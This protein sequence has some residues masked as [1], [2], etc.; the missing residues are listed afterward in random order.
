VKVLKW[1]RYGFLSLGFIYYLSAMITASFLP[2]NF[3]SSEVNSI[4]FIIYAIL[5][6]IALCCEK[7]KSSPLILYNFGIIMTCKIFWSSPYQ[8]IYKLLNDS[9]RAQLTT[10]IIEWTFY[11]LTG[12]LLIT[13]VILEIIKIFKKMHNDKLN[14]LSKA[15]TLSGMVTF[16]LFVLTLDFV[17]SEPVMCL[18][19]LRSVYDIVGDML[20]IYF[21]GMFP[22]FIVGIAIKFIYLIINKKRRVENEKQ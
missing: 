14:V 7:S 11:I 16:I 5:S 20:P 18:D 15:F 9:Q 8:S 21:F 19:S 22:L 17:T 1:F 13:G 3:Y 4:F 10:E 12:F 2:F 6:I